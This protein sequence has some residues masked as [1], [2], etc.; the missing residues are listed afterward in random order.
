M[1]IYLPEVK[2]RRGEA[3][4]Y[5]FQGKNRD[6]LKESAAAE[7]G[8]TLNLSVRS[9]DDK[10]MVSGRFE[11]GITVNCSRCLRPFRQQIDSEIDEI[12]TVSPLPDK[13]SS[14]ED[15]AEETANQ[16]T[17]RGDYLYL[18]EYIRQLFI[19]SQVYNPLCQPDCRGLCPG[20]GTDLNESTCSCVDE[21]G[22]G[23]RLLKLKEFQPDR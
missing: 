16:L 19:I 15:L 7:N 2:E 8:F 5:R 21:A 4:Q 11:A 3:L 17:V 23:L 14:P 9:S 6:Y 20:C 13:K 22:I 12:F 10:I 1:R 18:D